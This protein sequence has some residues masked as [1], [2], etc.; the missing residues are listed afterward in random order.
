MVKLDATGQPAWS[1]FSGDTEEVTATDV[2]VGV[3]NAIFT[4]GVFQTTNAAGA[5]THVLFVV[6]LAS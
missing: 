4:G 1:R 2:A 5:T 3:D 6:K